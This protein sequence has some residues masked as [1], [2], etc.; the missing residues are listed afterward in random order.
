MKPF[1]RSELC[2]IGWIV[3]ISAL[4]SCAG[5]EPPTG[6]PP[7]EST[8]NAFSIAARADKP[9]AHGFTHAIIYSFQSNGDA[10]YPGAENAPL[11]AFHG[12]LYGTTGTGG[13]AGCGADGCGTVFRVTTSGAETV[14]YAFGG[15]DGAYPSG[16]VINY[17]NTWY[18]VAGGGGAFNYGCVFAV[19]NA[20]RERVLYSFKGQPDGSYPYG[21]LL[22]YKGNFYGT[23]ESGGKRN[24]GT[25]YVVT[26]TGKERVLHNFQFNSDGAQPYDGLTALSGKFYGTT[27][28]GGAGDF[29]TVFEVDPSGSE[30]VVYS[31]QYGNDGAAPQAPLTVISDNLYGTTTDGGGAGYLGTA[32]EVTPTGSETI[33]HRFAE[34]INDG[35]FPQS[36]LLYHNGSLFGTTYLGGRQDD[37]IVFRLSMSGKEDVL[38]YFQGAP[39]DGRYPSGGLVAI[40]DNLY[41]MTYNGGSGGCA[42]NDGCGV[43]Y[44]MK[45]T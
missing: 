33:L 24:L 30:R 42:Y 3:A 27:I 15:S 5:L 41:G 1:L 28:S 7:S 13:E 4:A 34:S 14:V 43:V 31:F 18:G 25:V 36:T 11:T 40:G 20:G 26:P 39:K 2:A 44:A 45:P 35:N 16:P 22:L 38:H 21:S 6:S 32:F 9:L 10:E 37:G 8:L 23:T 12:A 19:T 17:K 29:G